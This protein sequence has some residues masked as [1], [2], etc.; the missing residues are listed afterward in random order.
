VSAKEKDDSVVPFKGAKL[1]RRQA[2]RIGFSLICGFVA[3]IV[4]VPTIGDNNP[5]VTK[6]LVISA[7]VLAFNLYRRR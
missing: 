5:L 1:N 4:L 6:V 2:N 3:A 7:A